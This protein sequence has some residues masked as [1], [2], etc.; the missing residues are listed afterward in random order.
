M[1]IPGHGRIADEHDVLEYRDMVVIVRDRI[2]SMIDDGLTLA[3]VQEANPTFEYDPRYGADSGFWTTGDFVEA[4][5]LS[6][7]EG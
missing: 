3:Q 7:S 5:Y 1:V 2:Q 6:L 4:V